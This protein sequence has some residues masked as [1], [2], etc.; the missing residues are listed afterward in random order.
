MSFEGGLPLS[1]GFW[2]FG[3]APFVLFPL[4]LLL[5]FLYFMSGMTS[6]WFL[7]VAGNVGPHAVIYLFS[8]G[9]SWRY[10]SIFF[11]AQKVQMI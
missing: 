8:L 7:R 10:R 3:P 9:R 2:I 11:L 4:L 6:G 1:G 5:L